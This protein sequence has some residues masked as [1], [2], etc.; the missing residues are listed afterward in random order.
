MHKRAA[1]VILCLSLLPGTTGHA[2][3]G[4]VVSPFSADSAESVLISQIN[5]LLKR[6]ETI[7]GEFVQSIKIAALSRPVESAGR[8][9]FQAA[10][11]IAWYV[12][13]PLP[14]SIFIN[15]QGQLS[16]SAAGMRSQPTGMQWIA[17]LTQSLLL[18]DLAR[19]SS[20]FDLAGESGEEA[21]AIQLTPTEPLLAQLFERV[22]M[23]GSDIVQQIVLHTTTND[24]IHIRFLNVRSLAMLPAAVAADMGIATH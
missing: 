18:G 4:S 9:Y 7:A 15:E 22:D 2:S 20:M 16:G 12:D 21:W 3:D 13:S 6:D 14:S 5:A 10:R 19:L 1:I 17:D 23:S 11:G 24:R 8:F